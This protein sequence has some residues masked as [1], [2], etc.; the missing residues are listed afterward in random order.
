MI[1]RR[2]VVKAAGALAAA[3]AIPV[4][5]AKAAPPLESGERYVDV[6]GGR[7]WVD[8][9]GGGRRTP[10]VVLHGGPGAGHDYLEPLGD[11]AEDRAVVFYDQLGCGRSDHPD[12]PA[13]WTI[14]RFV[15]EL[16]AV[17]RALRLDRC[18]LYGHSWG[19][20]LA[21][22]YLLRRPRGV[23]SVVLA[24]T[25]AGA[26]EFV[27]GTKYLRSLLPPDV[28]Q[29]LDKYEAQG[30]FTA[31][32]YLDAVNVFYANFLCRLSPYPAAIQRSFDI[33]DGNQVYAAMNGPNEFVMT[34]NLASWDRTAEVR[35]ITEPVLLTR[36]RYDEMAETC[37]VTLRKNLPHAR[38]VEFPHSSHLAMWED[39]AAYRRTVS[40]FLSTWD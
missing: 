34:G 22:E 4:P 10:L 28:Q 24:S 35:R 14:G 38:T 18:H 6:P 15:A 31:P 33:L 5:A 25:S 2:S 3:G 39:R 23:K 27:A 36:G 13:L 7:V 40:S 26:P 17:R 1:N 8:V 19:G 30:D 21:I 37:T 32:E 11:L 9:V 16:Q 12:D 20:W 29:T